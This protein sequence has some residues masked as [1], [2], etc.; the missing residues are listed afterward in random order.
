MLLGG[1]EVTVI[2]VIPFWAGRAGTGRSVIARR[3]ASEQAWG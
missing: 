2:W 3:G 1:M